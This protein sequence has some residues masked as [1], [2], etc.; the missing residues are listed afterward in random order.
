MALEPDPYLSFIRGDKKNT[1]KSAQQEVL[2]TPECTPHLKRIL[3]D[4]LD[5]RKALSDPE[6][7]SWLNYLIA[8]GK[9][10]SDFASIVKTFDNAVSCGLV[11]TANFVAYRCRTC[12][13]SPCMSLCAEC[14]QK[15]NH[16]GHDYN[17]FRSQAGGACDCGDPSVMKESGFCS[18]HQPGVSDR[19]PRAPHDLTCV[20]KAILPR[21]LYRLVLQLRKNSPDALRDT[22]DF[23]TNVL[24]SMTE[25]GA[26]MRAVMTGPLI[27][28]QVYSSLAMSE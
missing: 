21:L 25:M 5:P 3:D 24:T 13:I 19:K 20:A 10:P 26:A 9:N 22:D 17:M 27:D 6:V 15:G 2:K 11:W 4:L 18:S 14:F 1:A 7:I 16:E 8:G 12:G 28:P 23:L